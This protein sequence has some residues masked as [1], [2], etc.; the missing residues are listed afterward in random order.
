M[1]SIKLYNEYEGFLIQ[2]VLGAGAFAKVYDYMISTKKSSAMKVIPANDDVYLEIIN[3]SKLYHPN[4]LKIER[5]WRDNTGEPF[6]VLLLLEVLLKVSNSVKYTSQIC[7]DHPEGLPGYLILKYLNQSARVFK[8][9]RKHNII[10][11]PENVLIDEFGNLK[12]PD[13]GLSQTGSTQRTLTNVGGTRHYMSPECTF[14]GK[15]CA[16]TDIWSLEIMFYEL[17]HGHRPE[18]ILGVLTN[19]ERP[20]FAD[21]INEEIKDLILRM[22]VANPD[23]RLDF[24]K[25]FEFAD[26]NCTV[27][28]FPCLISQV[29]SWRI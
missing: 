18:N 16:L 26:I 13:F 10:H 21:N 6:I 17:L 8:E 15:V 7:L 14:G 2:K 3:M 20:V 4:I 28:P 25:F 29:S 23:D 19:K 22:L 24:V 12:F 1:D 5:C 11:K 27:S 9:F